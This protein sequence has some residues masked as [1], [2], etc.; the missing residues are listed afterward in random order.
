MQTDRVN[1]GNKSIHVEG[2]F[3]L[4]VLKD[5]KKFSL[6]NI[7]AFVPLGKSAKDRIRFKTE[8]GEVDS[9][10]IDRI[11]VLFNPQKE[12]DRHNVWA[13]IQ[14]RDVRIGGMSDEEH[15]KLVDQNI[16]SARPEFRLTNVDR[17]EDEAHE[18]EVNLLKVRSKLYSDENPLSKKKLIWFCS[19][20][21]IPYKTDITDTKKYIADLQKRID[22]HISG[23]TAIAM[24]FDKDISEMNKVEMRFYI[25]E[26]IS[27][28]IVQ[29][30]YG[31]YKIND[32]PI[33]AGIDH[34]MKFY[35][36]NPTIYLEHQKLVHENLGT[37]YS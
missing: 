18:Q 36:D 27:L 20:Y 24:Q 31:V 3:K 21:G 35:D 7:N 34:V 1:L 32:R 37:I 14:H 26:L 2:R 17:V 33:G 22:K 25:N 23:S 4:E 12:I 9:L 8:S 10:F 28:Q 13:M 11:S 19:N 15:Q 29:E 5:Q 6:T 16:K 30:F